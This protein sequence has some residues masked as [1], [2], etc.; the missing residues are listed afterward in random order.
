V[1]FCFQEKEICRRQLYNDR[2][3]G[4]GVFIYL[5]GSKYDG[6]WKDNEKHGVGKLTLPNG[7]IYEGLYYNESKMLYARGY[8]GCRRQQCV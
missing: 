8:Y 5:D 6:E 2:R 3:H 4:N 1:G 7:Q